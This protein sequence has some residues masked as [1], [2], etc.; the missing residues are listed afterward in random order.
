MDGLEITA[1]KGTLL[2][3]RDRLG[4]VGNIESTLEFDLQINCQICFT[5]AMRDFA[6]GLLSGRPFQTDRLDN[7]E[8]LRLMEVCYSSPATSSA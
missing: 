5:S 6:E 1:N 7:L 2:F 3:D 4:L 8:A